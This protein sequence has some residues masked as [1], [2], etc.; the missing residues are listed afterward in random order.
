MN[1]QSTTPV[2]FIGIFFITLIV[3]GSSLAFHFHGFT[4]K[5]SSAVKIEE[6]QKTLE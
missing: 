5:D 1:E 6:A 2:F 3:L 4:K